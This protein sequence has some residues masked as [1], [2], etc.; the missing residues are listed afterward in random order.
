MHLALT[1]G[2]FAEVD[3]TFHTILDMFFVYYIFAVCNANDY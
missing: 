3:N 1:F 2:D